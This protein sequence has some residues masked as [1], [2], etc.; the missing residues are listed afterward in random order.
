M[1]F[2]YDL[3]YL[4]LKKSIWQT[5]CNSYVVFNFVSINTVIVFA[6][7]SGLIW[8]E[9]VYKTLTATCETFIQ[10][11]IKTV[12][13][14]S[15]LWKFFVAL[16]FCCAHPTLLYWAHPPCLNVGCSSCN[17]GKNTEITDTLRPKHKPLIQ[18]ELEKM[19]SLSGYST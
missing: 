9:T 17:R 10:T 5:I 7:K 16:T 11:L 13:N 2:F 4:F 19:R 12:V 15:H 14:N 6:K 1:L 3:L 18:I 8:L